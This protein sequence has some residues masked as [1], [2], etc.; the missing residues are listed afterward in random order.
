[1]TPFFRARRT[2]GGFDVEGTL[3]CELGHRLPGGAGIFAAWSWDGERL[4]VTNDRYG[5]HPLFYCERDGEIM[6]SP[7]LVELVRRGAPTGLDDVALALFRSLRY[8]FFL[9][10]DTA[11]RHIKLVPP[12]ALFEWDGRLTVQERRPRPIGSPMDISREE[13]LHEIGRAHV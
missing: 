1:M 8:S 9:G 3:S 2:A 12:G 7:S 4:T 13:A 5:F 6:I 10:G 11:F